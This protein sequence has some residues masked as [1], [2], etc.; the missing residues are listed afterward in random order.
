M[1]R[2]VLV[3]APP[4][5][6]TTVPRAVKSLAFLP[7]EL[8]ENFRS[9]SR[10]VTSV[11]ASV[12]TTARKPVLV[13]LAS[14]RASPSSELTAPLET[15]TAPP[16]SA[17]SSGRL[18]ATSPPATRRPRIKLLET[19]FPSQDGIREPVYVTSPSA[20]SS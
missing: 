9:A 4:V 7:S 18:P 11:S 6:T 3:S 12:P 10:S 17:A 13:A 14:L 16:S 1:V 19:P 20:P 5:A 15:V 2:V 8:S